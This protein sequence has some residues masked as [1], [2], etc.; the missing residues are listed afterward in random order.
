MYLYLI[1]KF[2]NIV[3]PPTTL[4]TLILFL[5]PFLVFKC[6]FY[7]FRAI[8]SENV[9]GKVVL[10]TGASS[11]IGEQLAY[12]YAK[13]GAR[14]LL[15][16]RRKNCL[17][18][19]AEK[20]RGFGS[21][22]VVVVQADVSKVDDCKRFVDEAISHFGRMDHLV[23]N[24]GIAS[25]CMFEDSS[26][27]TKFAPIM[28]TN[29]WGSV[30]TAYFAVPHLRKSKGKII[31]NASSAG[32]LPLPRMSVYN[33]SKAAV[34][35]FYETLR[36]ELGRDIGITI[37]TPGFTE[38]EMMQGKFLTKEGE[39]QVDQEMRDVE[40]GTFP[41]EKAEGC[42]KAIVKS[43]C[44]GDRYLT[45]P[46]WFRVMFVWKVVCPHV[47]E[48]FY[49]LLYVTPPGTSQRDA[50]S[51]KILHHTAANNLLYPSSIQSLETRAD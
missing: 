17:Q 26:D 6:F 24:A 19:V 7:I 21:P 4:I 28:D 3:A 32:W 50:P 11:G 29:F 47:L 1:H 23:S 49:R 46:L 15:V 38:S 5:P 22:D 39:M 44:R 2:M 33:A 12:Q 30:Y 13:R 42:A 48:W 36:V 27:I 14:L 34:I 16:A 25:V 8:F 45:Q 51:K 40:V 35:N 43:A 18:E 20:A 9:A 37:V 41:V 31:V 10:I